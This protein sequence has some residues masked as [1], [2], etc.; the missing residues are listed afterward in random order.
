MIKGESYFQYS[1]EGYDEAGYKLVSR[2]IMEA[3]IEEKL[4]GIRD[5]TFDYKTEIAQKI[6]MI[7]ISLDSFL[8]ISTK[9]E[10]NFVIKTTVDGLNKFMIPE[11]RYREIT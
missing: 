8:H 5:T 4:V 10:Y 1:S 7:L 9:S 6:K 2:D 3:E 11:K